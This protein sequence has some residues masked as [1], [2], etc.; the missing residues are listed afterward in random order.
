[1]KK[2]QV[3]LPDEVALLLETMASESGQPASNLASG[4]LSREVYEE[5]SRR[6]KGI[7]YLRYAGVYVKREQDNS[8]ATDNGNG[9][10]EN[11]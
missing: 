8:G 2:L 5:A 1:M 7:N 11:V 10:Q 9:G 6:F 3:Y 4:L